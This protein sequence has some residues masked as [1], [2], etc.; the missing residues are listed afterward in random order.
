[1]LVRSSSKQTMK[2]LFILS[3]VAVLVVAGAAT[4]F[5]KLKEAQKLEQSKQEETRRAERIK[6]VIEFEQSALD[7]ASR[8]LMIFEHEQTHMVRL[9]KML[10]DVAQRNNVSEAQAVKTYW[11]GTGK[12]SIRESFEKLKDSYDKA[13]EDSGK[14]KTPEGCELIS[15]AQKSLASSTEAF[16]KRYSKE[17]PE[18]LEDF[19]NEFALSGKAVLKNFNILLSEIKRDVLPPQGWG[20]SASYERVSET[21]FSDVSMSKEYHFLASGVVI[22]E[23][24]LKLVLSVKMFLVTTYVVQTNNIIMSGRNGGHEIFRNDGDSLVLIANTDPERDSSKP[25]EQE[26]FKQIR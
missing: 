12:Q 11:D 5:F 2:W 3:V 26:R 9:V 6:Q 25:F 1:M 13:V 7:T 16:V 14:I 21:E 8:L 24:D 20:R 22:M 10:Q 18:S 19:A 4:R 15:Q 17:P 23:N